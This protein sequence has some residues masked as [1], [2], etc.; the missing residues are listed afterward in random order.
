MTKR[1]ANSVTNITEQLIQQ[2]DSPFFRR[3]PGS[4]CLEPG[5]SSQPKQE[6]ENETSEEEQLPEYEMEVEDDETLD[7]SHLPWEN[8]VV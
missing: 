1:H 7:N 8:P 6:S 2:E 3:K 5:S 4:K